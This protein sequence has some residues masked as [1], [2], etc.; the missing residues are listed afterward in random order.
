MSNLPKRMQL[1]RLRSHLIPFN[2][3]MAK[4][5]KRYQ[6]NILYAKRWNAKLAKSTVFFKRFFGVSLS[7]MFLFR[8]ISD[9]L[10]GF[11]RQSINGYMNMVS[12]TDAVYKSI[13]QLKGGFEAL[14][15]S[16]VQAMDQAGIF[17]MLTNAL[18]SLVTWFENLTPAQQQATAKAIIFAAVGSKILSVLANIGIL[19]ISAK[20]A[21]KGLFGAMIKGAGAALSAIAGLPAALIAVIVALLAGWAINWKETWK[22]LKNYFVSIT[23]DFK[24]LW[25][26][27][28]KAFRTIGQGFMDLLHGDFK[29]GFKKIGAAII[30]ILVSAFEFAFKIGY[31]IVKSSVNLIIDALNGLL[32]G[33]DWIAE[34][35]GLN[36][37]YRIS[38]KMPKY[39][40]GLTD[41]VNRWID[42]WAGTNLYGAPSS[43]TKNVSFNNE[44]NVSIEGVGD[45]SKE[46]LERL[47]ES[48]TEGV[49]EG[50]NK[51]LAQQGVTY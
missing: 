20:I 24:D 2:V 32:K 44:F 6:D 16:F 22:D 38:W 21:F 33:I 40:L 26:N 12:Q 43:K 19:V 23:Q 50:I 36:M 15:Y 30:S 39:N 49:T 8:Q 10:F 13:M 27:L 5:T 51:S 1:D 18:R 34:K 31:G 28:G 37:D 42:S 11:I 46:N 41:R 25:E 29:T 48:F 35:V 17:D 14:K 4:I 47:K 9:T 45:F 3:E 7:T